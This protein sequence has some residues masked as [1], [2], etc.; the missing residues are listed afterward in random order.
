MR[1]TAVILALATA[2][3]GLGATPALATPVCTDGYKGGPPLAT[4]G[5]RI[6]PEAANSQAYIQYR[7]NATGFSEFLHGAEFMAQKY[8]RWVS[9]YTLS[10]KYGELAKSVGDDG[11]RPG[12]DGDTGD[13]REI[14]VVKLTDHEKPDKGK[15]TLYFSLSVHGNERGGLEGGMRAIEDLAMDAEGGGTI[16]DGVDNYTS[17]TGTQPEFHEYEVADVLAKEAVYF[18]SFNPDGWAVG[19]LVGGAPLPYERANGANT[20]LNRQM[21][22]KGSINISRN[23]LTEPEAKFGV[24]DMHRV[25]AEGING[26]MAYGADV[27]GELTSRAY[28][29]IMYPAGQ[30][31]SVKHRQLMA[32]AE[33][34]KSVIDETLYAGIQNE[35]EEATGGNESEGIEETLPVPGNT[36]PTMPAHWAT[37][38]DTLGYTDTGFIGDYL[39]TD[40]GVTGMDYEIMLNHTV[41]DKA[42]NVY[43]QE[44]HINASRAIIKTAMAYALT[45]SQEFND[46]NVKLETGGQAGYVLNPDRVTDKD[47]D[48]PGAGFSPEGS[49]GSKIK[50]APYDVSNMDFFTETNRLMPKPFVALLPA[51]IANDAKHLDQ[52]DTLV[53]ADIAL[54]RDAKNRPVNAAKYY[55]NIKSWVERGGNLVLTDRGVPVAG[56]LGVVP[57][58]AIADETVYQPNATSIN[59]EHALTAGLRGNAKQLVEAAILGYGIGAD[60]SPMTVVD[61]AALTDAGGTVLG[62]IEKGTGEVTTVASL[63]ELSLGKGLIRL[64]GGALPMPTEENDH[65]YGLRSYG[66]TYSGLFIMENAVRYDAAGLGTAAP[67][68]FTPVRPAPEKPRPTTPA[69]PLPATGAGWELALAGGAF[70]ALAAQL[71][72]RRAAQRAA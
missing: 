56:T 41:P 36:I 15:E 32:I 13:G 5:L 65:R 27:H 53:L 66:L 7:P 59:F 40:L 19:D 50:Q 44:N 38:W 11:L 10:S 17:G 35:I 62:H 46:K 8:P 47:K 20:D 63:G 25:A 18:T 30:F 1:R 57:A 52:V 12:E 48:G 58:D 67:R 60:A 71:R 33:R 51:D 43:L 22:T 3:V 64:I 2:V 21:P 37:V 54:P 39:A 42:W 6:F 69:R 28:V 31:D 4:C 68:G 49:D 72:R 26:L 16:V 14:L 29:D 61:A 45:Q 34:T 55:A 23:P 70:L 24:K 9:V